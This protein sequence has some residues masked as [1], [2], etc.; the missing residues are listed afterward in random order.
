MYLL[1]LVDICHNVVYFYQY[2]GPDL[3]KKAEQGVVSDVLMDLKEKY[4]SDI[5]LIPLAADN[6]ITSISLMMDIYNIDY[7]PT[8]L[9][10]EDERVEGL[11]S[12]DEL[13]EVIES[14]E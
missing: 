12:V 14:L 1:H 2:N 11:T 4:G 10:D 7:L 8:I 3:D 13:E 9:I 6:N 5:L